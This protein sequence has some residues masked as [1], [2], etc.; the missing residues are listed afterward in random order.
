M[1]TRTT[2]QDSRSS[3]GMYSYK[4]QPT[5]ELLKTEPNKRQKS[6]PTRND[7]MY[8]NLPEAATRNGSRTSKEEGL[9]PNRK[10]PI[11]HSKSK[12]SKIF[13]TCF[14][15]CSFSCFFPIKVLKIGLYGR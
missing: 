9:S 6:Q 5:R 14:D 13:P 2:Y 12:R 3:Q 8:T 7:P 1:R 15:A 4:L 10:Q 11:R